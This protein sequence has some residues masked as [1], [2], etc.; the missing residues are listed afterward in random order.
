MRYLFTAALAI[1]AAASCRPD[2][3]ENST[4]SEKAALADQLLQDGDAEQ[5]L[6]LI[7]SALDSEPSSPDAPVW[8]ITR[9]ESL[10]DLGRRDE[11][12]AVASRYT[13]SANPVVKSRALFLKARVEAG[14][15]PSSALNTLAAV[16]LENLDSYRARLAAEL[17]REQLN[18]IQTGA[19]ADYRSRG[20]LELYVLL[21]LEERNATTGDYAR[22]ALYGDEIDRLY[23]GAHNLW[24]RPDYG[25]PE[26]ASDS[27]IAMLLPLTGEGAVYGRQVS[28]GAHL[29]FDRFSE[30]HSDSPQLVDFDTRG[31]PERLMELMQELADNPSCI[32]ILGPLTSSSTL[33]AASIAER[34]GIPLLSPTATSGSVDNIG[35]PVFRLVVSAGNQAAAVAEYAVRHEGLSRFAVIHPYTSQATG[36]AEQFKSVVERLGGTVVS[37][38]GYQPGD[39]DFRAQITAVKAYSPQAVFLPVSAWDAVQI[40]PQLRFYR[41]EVPLF[42][43]SGWDDDLLLRHG[44]EY[45]EGAVFTVAFGLNSLYPETA[46]FVYGYN[47]TYGQEPTAIAAQGY[48]AAGMLL[49][50]WAQASTPTRSRIARKLS[51]MGPWYGASGRCIL[52]SDTETRVS[53]PMMTVVDGEI[54]GID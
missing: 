14:S 20:W 39:T 44:G 41:V 15:S 50:A 30:M 51:S 26:T 19:L 37:S 16:D 5:A 2:I 35:S 34:A 32:A 29:A 33:N 53:W 38:Q 6:T 36:E 10:L 1:L 12:L 23:P 11:A 43:T 18:H 8:S 4:A 49:D 7:D 22:A 17:C 47:R 31:D 28:Q 9:G 54:I 52:G 42:G 21:E 45:V 3:N 27:W 40:A 13:A 48:D 46:R 25:Q 24:G